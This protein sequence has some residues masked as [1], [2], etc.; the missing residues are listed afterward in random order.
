MFRHGRDSTVTCYIYKTNSFIFFRHERDSDLLHQMK[1]CS[2]LE[3]DGT[4][5][6]LY[7]ALCLEV[8]LAGG[9]CRLFLSVVLIIVYELNFL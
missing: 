8:A 9:N 5:F 4:I 1:F 6:M 2:E 3:S 7:C